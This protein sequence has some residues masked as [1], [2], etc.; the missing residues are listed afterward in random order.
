MFKMKTRTRH[1]DFV[2][3]ERIKRKW[4]IKGAKV[5]QYRLGIQKDLF[6]WGRWAYCYFTSK[7]LSLLCLGESWFDANYA[8]WRCGHL[9]AIPPAGQASKRAA[10]MRAVLKMSWTTTMM[11]LGCRCQKWFEG[12]QATKQQ[13]WGQFWRWVRWWWNPCWR[14]C[15]WQGHQGGAPSDEQIKECKV[16]RKWSCFSHASWWFAWSCSLV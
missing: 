6:R 8:N 14:W 13:R 9:R 15:C 2:G 3:K 12:R 7:T 4:K 5:I 16:K 10:D 11:N 1:Q